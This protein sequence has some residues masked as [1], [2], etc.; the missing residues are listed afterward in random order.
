MGATVFWKRHT[1]KLLY[2]DPMVQHII[3]LQ[4]GLAQDK[5]KNNAMQGG[6]CVF[7]TPYWETIVFGSHEPIAIL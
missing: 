6:S 2:L 5:I 4:I 7:E 1:G 3:L